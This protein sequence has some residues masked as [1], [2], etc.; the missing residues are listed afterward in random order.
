MT[1][2]EMERRYQA[3]LNRMA[4]N[5]GMPLVMRCDPYTRETAERAFRQVGV[6]KLEA[7]VL[8]MILSLGMNQMI[9]ELTRRDPE[10]VATHC[11][12]N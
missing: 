1:A 8:S 4:D 7:L 11:D 9:L 2:Q 3:L 5:I 6:P 12:R 10:S